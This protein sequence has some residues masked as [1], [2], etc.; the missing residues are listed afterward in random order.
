MPDTLSTPQ[1]HIDIA[2]ANEGPMETGHAISLTQQEDAAGAEDDAPGHTET[3][4]RA[5]GGPDRRP[6]GWKSGS[7]CYTREPQATVQSGDLGSFRK[8][9]QSSTRG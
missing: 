2:T 8:A 3:P 7:H 6:A 9:F 5:G 1:T 4:C